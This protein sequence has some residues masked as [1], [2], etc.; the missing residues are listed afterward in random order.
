MKIGRCAVVLKWSPCDLSKLSFLVLAPCR[1]SKRGNKSR[2]T[3]RPVGPLK[4]LGVS[5]FSIT[6]GLEVQLLTHDSHLGNPIR[7]NDVLHT[8]V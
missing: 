7:T 3:S 2:P 6:S 5:V 1:G 4:R 8:P